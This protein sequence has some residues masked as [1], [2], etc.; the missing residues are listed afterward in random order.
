MQPQAQ[1]L[2]SPSISALRLL[3]CLSV[4][5]SSLEV[6][7]W[8]RGNRF[9]NTPLQYP[10]PLPRP[11]LKLTQ[12]PWG[13]P[14]PGLSLLS[15]HQEDEGQRPGLGGGRQG[16]KMGEAHKGSPAGPSPVWSCAWRMKINLSLNRAETGLSLVIHSP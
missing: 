13:L 3:S 12:A 4:K 14:Y 8:P 15:W 10:I 11:F 1:P 7:A 2:Q 16:R 9:Q 5:P 6:Q